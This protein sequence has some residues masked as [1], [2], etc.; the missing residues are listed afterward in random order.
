M[1]SSRVFE[2][3]NAGFAWGYS[4]LADRL[5]AWPA[6]LDTFIHYIISASARR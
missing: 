4:S 1:E 2:L 3:S 6:R 5:L